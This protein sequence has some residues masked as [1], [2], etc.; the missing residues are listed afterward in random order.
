MSIKLGR[1]TLFT[2][3]ELSER[4]NVTPLTLRSYIKKGKL[5]GRK[6]G[7]VWYVSD[8]SLRRFFNNPGQ[9]EGETSDSF[10]LNPLG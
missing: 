8:L 10:F 5:R 7:G 9:D 4:L 3:K 6:V 1:L 2:I